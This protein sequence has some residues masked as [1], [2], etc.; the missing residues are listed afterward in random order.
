MQ[1]AVGGSKKERELGMEGFGI[2][3]EKGERGREGNREVSFK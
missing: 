3:G 2:E 1:H